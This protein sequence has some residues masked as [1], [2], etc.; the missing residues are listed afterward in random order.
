MKK[1]ETEKKGGAWNSRKLAMF[2]KS[3]AEDKKASNVV[4]LN[5]K[6]KSG[7]TDYFVICSADSEPQ[8]KA[9]ANELEARVL[10]EAGMK[11]FARE[12]AV[13]S[14]W[15]I[16]DFVDVIVHIFHAKRREFYQIEEFW[17]DAP[18]IS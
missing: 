3:C 9:I 14:Q 12:G 4:V 1:N 13:A 2:C 11:P 6:N 10:E 5:M 7:I 18:K 15:L 17:N 16:V 8:I